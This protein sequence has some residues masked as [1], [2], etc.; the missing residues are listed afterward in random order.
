MPFTFAHPAAVLPIKKF[1]PRLSLP[2][3][4]AGSITP[5]LGYFLHN[6]M[7]AISGHSFL[8]SLTFDI[9]AGMILLGVFYLSVRSVARL[10]PYP[11]REACSQICPQL[12]L[13]SIGSLLVAAFSILVGAWTH[14]IWDGFTHAN[15]W[16]VREFA[17]LTPTVV[18]FYG[19]K[20]TV[21]QCLQHLSSI[22]GLSA[23]A[24]AYN[25]YA[26]SRR[27]LRH[28]DYLGNVVRNTLLA[29][30]VILPAVY[31]LVK[32]T[33]LVMHRGFDIQRLDVFSFNSIVLYVCIEIPVLIL[34]GIS[35]S[36]FE[37]LASQFAKPATQKLPSHAMQTS[38]RNE[39]ELP[40]LTQ[41]PIL[42]APGLA[43]PQTATGSNAV[44]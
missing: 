3:L 7:W 36:L 33:D 16:C 2:A 31:S 18:T 13:P 17:A 38:G 11:H 35:V 40:S 22:L 29:S 21:W 42:A 1:C 14:I 25:D 5:D 26:H 32:T 20:I 27:F 8:G 44:V 6:W 9:P 34:A 12:S 41:A 15:G 39:L 19:Y 23:L 43:S 37:Y 24:W 28:K 4:V 10:L 30:I